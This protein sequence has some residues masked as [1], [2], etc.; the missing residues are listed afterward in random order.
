[1][2][3]LILNSGKM[4]FMTTRNRLSLFPL[5]AALLAGG[6]IASP[7]WSR[8]PDPAA[9]AAIR[10]ATTQVARLQASRDSLSRLRWSLR[11][12]GL[13][14]RAR[15]QTDSDRVRDSLDKAGSERARL[16]EE[17]RDTR[18]RLAQV[19]PGPDAVTKQRETLRQDMLDRAEMLRDKIR[20][21]LPW[22]TEA[23]AAAVVRVVRGIESYATPHEGLAPLIDAHVEEWN[24][25]RQIEKEA[26]E[27]PRATG[28]TALG[29]RVRIGTLGGWYLTRDNVTGLLARSGSGDM[30]YAWHENLL[31]QTQR[32]ILTGIDAPALELPV[33][34][35]QARADGPGYFVAEEKSLLAK[36][37]DMKDGPLAKMPLLLAR[38]IIA[39]LVGL[40]IGCLVIFLRRRALIKREA[41]DA[42]AMRL[43]LF[44]ALTGRRGV[45]AVVGRAD[46]HTVAG[47]I[48]RLGYDNHALVPEALEQLMIS[49]ESVEERRLNKG[50]NYL[51]TV[52]ANAAFIGLLGTVLG[53]LDAFAH[54]GG[55]E[56][57]ATLHVMTAIAEALVATALGL[58]VA[59]PAVVFYNVLTHSVSDVMDEAREMR[60]LILAAGL[61]TAARG[62]RHDVDPKSGD[63]A[64]KSASKPVSQLQGASHGG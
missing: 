39:L 35:M 31:P 12:T 5:G 2:K 53:I 38:A 24:F 20:F 55:G 28:G 52:A 41:A 59:I 32:A 33:D 61:D 13:D 25:S 18:E 57:D 15:W 9:E 48:V 29:T 56:A 26:G 1:V 62:T 54:L 40:G 50:M 44:S 47:R 27:F 64:T 43:R 10:E 8:K 30:P 63:T 3:F 60:H 42:D 21:G 7:A 16:L 45:D 36:L 19:R 49:Q 17:I 58:A 14:A 11:Q 4:F 6:L 46:V 23:R 37:F 34:P 22:N 51:G